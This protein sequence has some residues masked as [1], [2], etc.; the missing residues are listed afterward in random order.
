MT[1]RTDWKELKQEAFALEPWLVQ[2]RHRL[3]ACPERGF[4]E[5]KTAETAFMKLFQMIRLFLI[6]LKALKIGSK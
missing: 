3:H 4:E 1:D 5:W 2:L 6:L